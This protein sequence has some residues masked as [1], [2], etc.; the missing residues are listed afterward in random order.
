MGNGIASAILAPI[1]GTSDAIV[2]TTSHT[3]ATLT[4]SWTSS[5]TYTITMGPYY[6]TANGEIIVDIKDMYKHISKL[7]YEQ[8]M[9]EILSEESEC[10]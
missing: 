10:K 3:H 7:Y 5:L 8:Q 9:T 6:R 2:T 4:N 1:M